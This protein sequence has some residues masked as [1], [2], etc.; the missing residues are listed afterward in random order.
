MSCRRMIC[1]RS[2]CRSAFVPR[3]RALHARAAAVTESASWE[4]RALGTGCLDAA[5]ASGTVQ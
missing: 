3:R 5:A 1:P 4:H 2:S